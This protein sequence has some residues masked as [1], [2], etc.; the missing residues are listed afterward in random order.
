M[1]YW[2]MVVKKEKKDTPVFIYFAI[3]DKE[4]WDC[5]SVTEWVE[6]TFGWYTINRY[7]RSISPATYF[8]ALMAY[9]VTDHLDCF[10]HHRSVVLR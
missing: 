1:K 2:R 8:C 5:G 6:E 10:N 9:P 3:E 7:M 4:M